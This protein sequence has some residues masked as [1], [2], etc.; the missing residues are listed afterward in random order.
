MHFYYSIT[1]L[2]LFSGFTRKIYVTFFN[3]FLL[4]ISFKHVK[5]YQKLLIDKNTGIIYCAFRSSPPPPYE[6]HFFPPTNKVS[7]S[8]GTKFFKD[9][10]TKRCIFKTLNPFFMQFSLF[11]SPLFF[12]PKSEFFIFSPAAYY[13]KCLIYNQG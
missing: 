3:I 13:I 11:L 9:C 5:N 2:C 8:G 1:D 6:I 10:K 7:A 4:K 12:T